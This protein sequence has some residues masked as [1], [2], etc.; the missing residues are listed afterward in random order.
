MNLPAGLSAL[1]IRHHQ[2]LRPV[3]NLSDIFGVKKGLGIAFKESSIQNKRGSTHHFARFTI[4]S[5]YSWC[6]LATL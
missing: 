1:W 4:C 5:R 2:Q 3:P 6:T